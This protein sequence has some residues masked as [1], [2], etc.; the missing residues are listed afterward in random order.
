[1]IKNRITLSPGARTLVSTMKKNN[2]Y[3]ALI[4]GGFTHFTSKIAQELGFNESIA[5]QFQIKNEKLTGMVEPPILDKDAKVD[6]TQSLTKRFGLSP[7]DVIAVGDGA[8]DIGMLELVGSGVAMHA[9][10][11][12]QS[13]AK[14]IVNH[15]DLSAL[16]YIQGYN[17]N[18]FIN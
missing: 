11:I 7:M 2:V 3:T 5:N 12:V 4:S 6:F 16:L 18:E 13:K 10:K 17:F 1:M 9:K 15:S 8:N 14:I